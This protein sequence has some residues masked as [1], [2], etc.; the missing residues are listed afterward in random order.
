VF[1]VSRCF[2]TYHYRVA[3]ARRKATPR[4]PRASRAPAIRHRVPS[5]HVKKSHRWVPRAPMR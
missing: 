2:E 5:R 1:G 4:A 3:V